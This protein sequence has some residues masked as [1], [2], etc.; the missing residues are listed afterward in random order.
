MLEREFKNKRW[1]TIV[2]T[3]KD[4]LSTEVGINKAITALTGP[5]D[6][7]WHSQPCTGGCPWQR[8]NLRRNPATKDKVKQHWK[9]FAKLWKSFEIIANHAMSVGAAVYNEWPL[10]C[11]YWANKKVSAF[12]QKRHFNFAVVHGCM[13]GLM[14]EYG[15]QRESNQEA[16]ENSLLS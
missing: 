7:L 15:K 14:A 8:I 10:G 5:E 3:D 16:M 1:E 2:I 11:S 13:Y 9:L 12:F 6:V 4:D